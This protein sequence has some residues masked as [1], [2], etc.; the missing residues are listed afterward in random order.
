VQLKFLGSWTPKEDLEDLSERVRK[1]SV[2]KLKMA[3]F[4]LRNGQNQG[5]SVT[6][7]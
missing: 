5:F 1:R 2:F 6:D 7:S 3:D 4:G